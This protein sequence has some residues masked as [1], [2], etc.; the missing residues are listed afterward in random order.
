MVSSHSLSGSAGSADQIPAVDD[1]DV[2]LRPAA[3]HVDAELHHALDLG[4]RPG[5]GRSDRQRPGRGW[6]VAKPD[7]V[8]DAVEQLAG[9]PVPASA[10]ETLT[11]PG[12]VPGYQ[13][14]LLDELTAAGEIV[15]AGAGGLPGGDGWLV[16]AIAAGGGAPAT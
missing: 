7:A 10:L 4:Q 14:A 12:R 5:G 13:S 9:A 2:H 3:R 6:R 1:Q 15:W 11:L 8:Y 16:L